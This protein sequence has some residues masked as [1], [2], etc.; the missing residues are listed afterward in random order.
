MAPRM[1]RH[2]L[3]EL[4]PKCFKEMRGGP[5]SKKRSFG[6]EVARQADSFFKSD[7]LDQRKDCLFT[8][9]LL[10]LRTSYTEAAAQGVTT[11]KPDFVYGLRYSRYPDLDTPIL[12]NKSKAEIGVAPGVQHAFFS[13]D[14]KGSQ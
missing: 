5:A 1:R 13:V 6:E 10:P 4:L 2:T 9:N 3:L 7:G 14:N 12:S 8:K 11:A